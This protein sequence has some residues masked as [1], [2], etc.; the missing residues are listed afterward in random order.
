[1]KANMNLFVE[2]LR[3][4]LK[5]KKLKSLWQFFNT[6]LF[7]LL[8]TLVAGNFYLPGLL[9]NSQLKYQKELRDNEMKHE[10][11]LS[12]LD[13]SWKRLFLAKNFY[14]NVNSSDFEDRKNDLWNE[15]F[16][17]VKEWNMSL[18]GNFFTL[19]KYYD[20]NTRNY[21]DNE[22]SIN[23]VKLHEELL[24]IRHGEKYDSDEIDRLFSTLDNRMYILAEKLFY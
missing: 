23:F 11:S 2:S 5:R 19:E 21:F 14:W 1:M 16:S 24:K 15:Y 22:V 20:K 4:I 3:K 12:L 9:A 18:V 17:S 10:Y 8:L 6:P 7:L 13:M